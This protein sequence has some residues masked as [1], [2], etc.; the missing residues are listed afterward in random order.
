MLWQRMGLKKFKTCEFLCLHFSDDSE[1]QGSTTTRLEARR[2][3]AMNLSFPRAEPLPPYVD[4]Y[5]QAGHTHTHRNTAH[6]SCLPGPRGSPP[7]G[8]QT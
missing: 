3:P 6:H 1:T 2:T 7:R 4:I 8:T 5:A